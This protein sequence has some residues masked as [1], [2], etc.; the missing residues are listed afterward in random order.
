M[1]NR[2]RR[3]KI[4]FQI[5][6]MFFFPLTKSN[7]NLFLYVDAGEKAMSKSRLFVCFCMKEIRKDYRCLDSMRALI[8]RTVVPFCWNAFRLKNAFMEFIELY[9]RLSVMP[10]P[11]AMD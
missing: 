2:K 11:T 6:K 5:F 1:T 10:L 8:F 4:P 3:K 9:S 7:A